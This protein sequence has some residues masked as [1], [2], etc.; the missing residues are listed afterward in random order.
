MSIDNLKQFFFDRVFVRALYSPKSTL[1]C[2]ATLAVDRI[3]P[4]KANSIIIE[5]LGGF[6]TTTTTKTIV[7]DYSVLSEDNFVFV[8]STGNQITITLTALLAGKELFFKDQK[9]TAKTHNITIN[10]IN[11]TIDGD[12]TFVINSA[13]ACLHVV[14]DGANWLVV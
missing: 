14:S 8:N 6:G 7:S 12:S 1:E 5:G 9:G 3:K 11:C 13:Y 4:L 10:A 2:H